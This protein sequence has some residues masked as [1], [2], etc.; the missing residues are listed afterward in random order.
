MSSSST[1]RNKDETTVTPKSKSLSRS[2]F[3]VKVL[4]CLEHIK[5]QVQDNAKTLHVL[6]KKMNVTAGEDNEEDETVVLPDMPVKDEGHLEEVEQLLQ[7]NAAV[8]KRM[9]RSLSTIGGDNTKQSVRRIMKNLVSNS[10][11]M[12]LN[13]LG[14]GNKR[15]FSGLILKDVLFASVRRNRLCKEATDKEIEDVAK[16]WLKFSKD[17]EG[18]R[19]DRKEKKTADSESQNIE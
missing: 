9:I 4:T 13:W 10:L 2:E 19:K 14:R 15:P 6:E 8:K 11:A 16:D 3:E 12:K 1:Y 18:G 5:R 17:R 7:N